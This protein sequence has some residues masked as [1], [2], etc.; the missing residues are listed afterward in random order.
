MGELR[1]KKE[2]Y[3]PISLMKIDAK[4]IKKMEN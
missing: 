4:I 3:R 1:T 2:M